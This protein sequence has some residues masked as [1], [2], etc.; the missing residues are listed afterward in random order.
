MAKAKISGDMFGRSVTLH[1]EM[2]YYLPDDMDVSNVTP[3]EV[4]L[5]IQ[6]D[7]EFNLGQI[8]KNSLNETTVVT[9]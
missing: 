3:E 5:L 6:Q 4:K 8:L 7:K 2:N 1:I 9:E